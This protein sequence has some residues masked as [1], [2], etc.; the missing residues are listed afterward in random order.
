MCSEVVDIN[1]PSSSNVFVIIDPSEKNKLLIEEN[2]E[3]NDYVVKERVY[4]GKKE[5]SMTV[6][7]INH[8]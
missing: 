6:N 7:T 2:Q 4:H 3:Y 5:I 1:N 8:L